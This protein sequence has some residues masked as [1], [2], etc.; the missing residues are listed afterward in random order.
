M[1]GDIIKLDQPRSKGLAEPLHHASDAG[2]VVV[3]GTDEGEK[4]LEGVLLQEPN[5]WGPER[6]GDQKAPQSWEWPPL[7]LRS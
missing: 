6:Q 5:T 2:N 1:I 7:T 4:A 3:G